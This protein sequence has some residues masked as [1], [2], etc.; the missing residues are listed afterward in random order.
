[1]YLNQLIGQGGDLVSWLVS[2]TFFMVFFMFYPRIMLS[3]MMW[4]L[5][6]SA[7]K[8]ERMSLQSR[9][10]LMREI[11]KRPNSVVKESVDRFFEFFAIEPV[12]LDPYGIVKK[13]DHLI[14]NEND[15]FRYFVNQVAPKL[16]EEKKA[17]IQMGMA[18]G[19]QLHMVAKIVRHFVEMIKKTKSY[20]IAMIIQMQLPLIEKMAQALS[21]GTRSLARGEPIGD[22]IGPWIVANLS[23]NQKTREIE[24]DIILAEKVIDGRKAFLLRA[25]GP[26][27]RVGYPG[28]A[29]EKL[30]KKNRIARIITIDAAAKL[31]GEATGS[32]AEGVGV[33]M[34]GPG[35]E[36]SY[37]EDAA[38]KQ[39]I[40]IDSIIVK[41][42]SEEAIQPM[43]KT[44][45][46]SLPKVKDSI[47][48]S[49]SRT[50]KGDKVI[51]VGVGNS[52]GIGTGRADAEKTARWVEKYERKLK[53]KKKKD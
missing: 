43:R 41:M 2:I 39:D 33:A 6:A 23:E 28:K 27:G 47:K 14:K 25:K 10:F 8:L 18:G 12:S 34:G 53:T 16:G 52:S 4:K 45:I 38:V 7:R 3:Q 17:N 19:I 26:G 49:I 50:K 5:E 15:R 1:M 37:I 22:G 36:R 20:Q 13:L 31:E 44:M 32:I 42:S 24:E 9:K 29:V 46:K 48:R 11:S 30:M 21:D 35:T 51:I 40:P